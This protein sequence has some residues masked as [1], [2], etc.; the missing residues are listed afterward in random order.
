MAS[1]LIVDGL[2]A[3]NGNLFTACDYVVGLGS[4]YKSDQKE[5]W[6]RRVIQFADRY[7]ESNI[8]K[9][10][11]LLKEV[12]HWKLW[13]DLNREYKDVDYSSL[14]EES[15]ETTISDTIACAGGTCQLI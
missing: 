9:C 11:Y 8:K 6:K 7:C 1:G 2:A 5:D 15:D 12:H 10:L 14:I 4:E 3:F 13:L